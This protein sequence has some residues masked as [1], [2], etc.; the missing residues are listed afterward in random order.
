MKLTLATGSPAPRC[1]KMADH[2]PARC[3]QR[4]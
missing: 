2:L 4:L 1:D 3:R